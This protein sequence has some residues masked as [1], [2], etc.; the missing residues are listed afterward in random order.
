[1][2]YFLPFIL[3]T[4]LLMGT[5]CKTNGQTADTLAGRSSAAAG[6]CM[7]G[8]TLKKN[9]G[10]AKC[11]GAYLIEEWGKF[12][13]WVVREIKESGI[14]GGAI[15]HS[16]EIAPDDS[17]IGNIPY[18]NPQGCVWSTS[19]VMAVVSGVTKVSCSVF[20]EKRGDGNCA[21]LET[22]LEKVKVL[23]LVNLN[24]V[25]SGTV[26]LGYIR[27]PVRD[28]KNP[29]GKLCVG[30][31]FTDRPKAIQL[32]FKTI[33]GHNRLRAGGLGAPKSLGDDDYSECA[34]YL[35]KRWED[36]Q[37]NVYAMRVGTAYERFTSTDTTWNNGHQIEIKYGNITNE[38][39]Y[40]EFMQLV[41]Q[42]VEQYT[43]NSRGEAVPIKEIEW[44]ESGTEAPTHIVLRISASHG[45]AYVGDITNRLWID[46]VKLVY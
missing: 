44:D 27:E 35:Q 8:S 14:I 22:R 29:Q 23:G 9:G 34:L 37:G 19:S 17:I 21:R 39:F 5:F 40:R 36:D 3:T 16:Y 1:M 41:P 32:D 28:T 26:F 18:R 43:V 7:A 42:E 25:A 13:K 6:S 38:P 20:P 2:R 11:E 15:K 10:V 4:L 31:P 33:V 45:E 12:D 30:I 24:V 46:N